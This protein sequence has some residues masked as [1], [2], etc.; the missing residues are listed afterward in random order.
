MAKEEFFSAVAR[1]RSEFVKLAWVEA[2]DSRI[3][4]AELEGEFDFMA[5]SEA[6]G[7]WRLRSVE[8]GGTEMGDV[9][10]LESDEADDAGEGGETSSSPRRFSSSA[11]DG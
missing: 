6:E 3:G 9:S 7:W 10:C 5:E 2:S 8:M 1:E 4:A 11:E